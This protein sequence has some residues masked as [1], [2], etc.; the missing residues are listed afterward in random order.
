MLFKSEYGTDAFQRKRKPHIGRPYHRAPPFFRWQKLSLRETEPAGKAYPFKL[1]VKSPFG[2]I[3]VRKSVKDLSRYS[4]AARKVN[5]PNLTAVNTVAEEKNIEVRAFAVFI[6]PAFL[7]IS[8]GKGLN[9]DFKVFVIPES[10]ASPQG[11]G[12]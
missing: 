1:C 7:K 8:G 3:L 11:S 4:F 12:Y 9:I 6:D 5:R 2:H 10:T